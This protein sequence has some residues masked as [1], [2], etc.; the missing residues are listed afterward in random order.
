MKVS[1]KPLKLK[2]NNF[3]ISVKNLPPSRQRP[4]KL[5]MVFEK[6]VH[7]ENNNLE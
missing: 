2:M 3:M 7:R 5:W 1:S 6:K 4:K